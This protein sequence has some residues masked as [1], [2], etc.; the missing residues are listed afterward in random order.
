MEY[1]SYLEIIPEEIIFQ[2]IFST[3]D[4]KNIYNF[5]IATGISKNKLVEYIGNKTAVSEIL[6]PQ[7]LL[8]RLTDQSKLGKLLNLINII[9]YNILITN[10]II[11]GSSVVEYIL[12]EDY[13][14]H[15]VDIFVSKKYWD[16]IKSSVISYSDG[17]GGIDNINM[18]TNEKD[19]KGYVNVQG[20]G[21]PSPLALY[22]FNILHRAYQFVILDVDSEEGV[23]D[24]L[25]KINDF[26]ML[27][28]FVG[29]RQAPSIGITFVYKPYL[30]IDYIDDLFDKKLVLNHSGVIKMERYL[31]Y[32]NRG[33]DYVFTPESFVDLIRGFFYPIVL[34]YYIENN[35]TLAGKYSKTME[36]IFSQNHIVI[37]CYQGCPLNHE[38]LERITKNLFKYVYHAH[39]LSS[40]YI[41]AH[42][43]KPQSDPHKLMIHRQS[44]GDFVVMDDPNDIL[45]SIRED[46]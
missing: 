25:R 10:S 9:N 17:H 6:Y 45:S 29:F 13:K 37:P 42:Q 41:L 5:I 44:I 27:R 30:I 4:N 20:M 36:E 46:E 14:E 1:I 39:Y 31:K 18:I 32:I 34:G 33:F 11:S 40:E 22:E 21:V 26:T 38:N 23:I 35:P 12:D 28:N 19:V 3:L 24:Y 2:H 43:F 7:R 8:E 15:D 16:V